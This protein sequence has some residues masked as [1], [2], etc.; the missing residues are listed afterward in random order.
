MRFSLVLASCALAV[1]C[2]DGSFA[3]PPSPMH[4]YRGNTHTHTKFSDDPSDVNAPPAEVANWY[5]QNGYQF[6]VV[7]DHEHLTD[8][9]PLNDAYGKNGD[10]LVLRGQEITQIVADAQQPDGMRHAHVNGINTDRLIMPIPF[11]TPGVS[12]AQT[13][14]R[15]FTEIEH[16]GGIPQINHP[17]LQWSVRLQDLMALRGPFL[18]EIWNGYPSSNNLGGAD[19]KGIAS[20]SAE[21]LWDSLV[22]TGKVAWGVASDDAHAYHD[23]EI[24]ESPNPGKAWIVAYASE[25][26]PEAIVDALRQGHFYASTGIQLSHYSSDEKEVSITIQRLRDWSELTSTT[27]YVTRFV[28]QGG[29]ILAEVSGL[30]PHYAFRGNEQYVRA[31]IIDSDG[32]RAW[33]QPVFRD[34]RTSK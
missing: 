23:F 33:T 21:A 26:N 29:K 28:G 1:I 32:R 24:R 34:K 12:M 31:S 25:L 22:S 18:V 6:V 3:Q 15:N 27:R 9:Q 30:S 8:V 10:F 20:P 13:Y 11:P 16:A 4:W 14:Q 2:G 19:D 17:N 7:T 5:K